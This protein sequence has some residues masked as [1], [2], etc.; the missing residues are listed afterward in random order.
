MLFM[1]RRSASVG[2]AS[3]SSPLFMIE[4]KRCCAPAKKALRSRSSLLD[5]AGFESSLKPALT[6]L[7]D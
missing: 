4:A 5:D 1:R 3:S 2:S 6:S 7:N